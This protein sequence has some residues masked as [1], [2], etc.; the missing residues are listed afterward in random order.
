MV[1]LLLIGLVTS[2]ATPLDGAASADERAARWRDFPVFV[3]FHGGPAPGPVAFATLREAGLAGCNVEAAWDGAR[4]A[5]VRAAGLDFYVDHLAGKGDLWLRPARFDLDREAWKGDLSGFRP[6]RPTSLL[7]PAAR[8]Q[9]FEKVEAGLARHRAAAPLCW[10]LEDE[11]SVTRGVNPMDYCFAPATLAA[12]RAWLAARHGAI[13]DWRARHG[14]TWDDWS[15]FVPPTSAEARR[16]AADRPLAEVRLAA[17]AVH[18]EF[19]D[20]A[21]ARLLVDL[22]A[23]VIAADPGAPVGFT[24]GSFPSAFGGFDWARLAPA[25]TLHEPYETGA[26]PEL[27]HAFKGAGARVLS[28]L[29]VP[30]QP[31]ADWEP[32]ELLARVGRGD[33]GAVIWSSGP[34][35]TAD[36]SA[37]T[38]AGR[39]LAEE[40]TQ[41]RRLR[42][43]LVD[44]VAAPPRVFLFSGMA[45][46]R[47]GWIVDSW[48]DGKTFLNRLTSYEADH[49]STAAAREGWVEL[50]RAVGVPFTF[51]DERAGLPGAAIADPP[52]AAVILT[53]A[54]AVSDRLVGELA[55]FVAAGGTLIGDA[56][57]ALFDEELAGR[58]SGALR[59]L[60]GVERRGGIEL[61]DLEPSV[62][63]DAPRTGAL[64][65][66]AAEGELLA[67]AAGTRRTSLGY[68]RTAAPG[69][70]LYLDARVG[71]CVRG[72]ERVEALRATA[73]A[74][75]GWL[76]HPVGAAVGGDAIELDAAS[77]GAVH[78][79]RLQ[80]RGRER[81]LVVAG[82][83][84]TEPRE[85]RLTRTRGGFAAVTPIGAAPAAATAGAPTAHASIALQLGPGGAALIELV[86]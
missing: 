11:L 81:L 24:G 45:A 49:S 40:V 86:D 75:R 28:T 26:A 31:A 46:A 47:A 48:G 21:L 65:L 22:A 9:L 30:D 25:L 50:L 14:G 72:A 7:E 6:S 79:H 59:S 74:L 62:A 5:A 39:R 2:T 1:S 80:R 3:W 56:H 58:D 23:P 12:L 66:A 27:V 17:W 69:R 43:E 15:E 71:G 34:L 35:L 4:S 8:G 32:R 55:A 52:S 44:A 41:A 42:R 64:R 61:A 63:L 85:I 16:A 36:G 19:M 37:L 76:G 78:L 13:A 68:E 77:I 29:F 70:A 38:R 84:L 51:F 33:D 20:E 82:S 54:F 53:E 60:F 83:G 10:V 18:R 57:A 67:A 73:A